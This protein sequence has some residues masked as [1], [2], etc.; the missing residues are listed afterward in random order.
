MNP[1][2]INTSTFTVKQGTTPISGTVTYSGLTAT[3]TPSS[4][5]APN[6]LFTATITTGAADLAGNPLVSSYV[7]SFRSGAA[8]PTLPT[9]ISTFPANG[10]APVTIT[11]NVIANFSE[12][13][14]PLT[15]NTATFLLKQGT[16]QVPGTVTYSGTAA[17]FT[18][19]GNLAPNTQ[20]NAVITSAAADL[21]GNTL[22]ASYLWSFTTGVPA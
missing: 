21:A 10:A 7:W 11:V 2:T 19:T 22:A 16:T 5:L 1:T 15:I 20:Y 17:T 6:T 14:N 4:A 8:L 9:V 12:A 13:M 18:P 3:F